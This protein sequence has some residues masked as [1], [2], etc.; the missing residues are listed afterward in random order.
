MPGEAPSAT[1]SALAGAL[2]WWREA[3]VDYAFGDAPRAWIA[4]PEPADSVPDAEPAPSAPPQPKLGGDS[5]GWPADLEAFA[6]WWLT[7]PTLDPGPPAERIAPRGPAAAKLMILVDHPEREDR[8]RLLDG[9]EG[10]LLDAFLSAAA[11]DPEQIYFASIL[12]RCTPLPDWDALARDG[13]GAIV[14]HHIAL[15]A[16]QRL[17]VFGANVSPLLGNGP[18]QSGPISEILNHD[19]PTVPVLVAPSLAGMIAKPARKAGLWKRWLE[20]TA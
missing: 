2:D 13:L 6:A 15:V 8:E 10:R 11:I 3:G 14:R 1:E 16:P 7:E 17:L 20:W 4:A 18:A 9:S 5:A 19:G 12:P